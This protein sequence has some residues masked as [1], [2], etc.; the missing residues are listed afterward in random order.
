MF[1]S[2]WHTPSKW[3]NDP[4]GYV[5]LPR[6]MH[7][8]GK[9]LYPN[10][11]T[12]DEP[13]TAAFSLLEPS[14]ALESQQIK[15]DV[16]EMLRNERPDFRRPSL[17][18]L[19]HET[20][21]TTLGISC[22]PIQ[23]SRDSIGLSPRPLVPIV[24]FTDDEW[25]AAGEIYR[26]RH[27]EARLAWRRYAKVRKT[28]TEACRHRQLAFGLRPRKGGAVYSGEASW[29]ETEGPT[30]QYRFNWF[31]MS[32]A[33]P[34]VNRL[35][36]NADWICI[37][38]DSLKKFLVN[39]G[40]TTRQSFG[41]RGRKPQYDATAFEAAVSNYVKAQGKTAAVNRGAIKAAMQE[42]CLE[43]WGTEPGATWLK[44]HIA[45]AINKLKSVAKSIND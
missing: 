9:V 31:C 19:P 24:T 23:F 20:S 18:E 5:F 41:T 43:N 42:W 39:L 21:P 37:V 22:G 2:L 38:R 35:G 11:W 25:R 3:I 15:Q 45:K 13:T 30:L 8:I 36:E 14:P 17:T 10:E 44:T 16:H 40:R 29:W 4:S 7:E 28:V 1:D 27:D 12:G 34:F 32:R 33:R 26:K 6:A